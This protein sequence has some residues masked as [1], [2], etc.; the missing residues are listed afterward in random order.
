MDG[1]GSHCHGRVPFALHLQQ[2]AI[3]DSLHDGKEHIIIED[4]D[5]R[6]VFELERRRLMGDFGIGF[7][8][9]GSEKVT[10]HGEQGNISVKFEG[11]Q[12]E[13]EAK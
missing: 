6:V 4:A 10:R 8:E 3:A 2:F 1:D 7:L 5:E 9:I 13:G 11:I 12:E